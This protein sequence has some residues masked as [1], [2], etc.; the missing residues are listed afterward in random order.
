MFNYDNACVLLAAS[1][2]C[3][4]ASVGFS[5]VTEVTYGCKAVKM[6]KDL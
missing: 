3:L 2:V 1:S 5:T 6:V 4:R